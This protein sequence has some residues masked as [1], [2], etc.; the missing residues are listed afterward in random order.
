MAIN[1]RTEQ[2]AHEDIRKLIIRFSTPTIIGMLVMASYNIVDGIFVGRGVGSLA[3]S[4]IGVYFPLMRI[5]MAFGMLIGIGATSRVSLALGRKDHDEAEKILGNAITLSIVI[6]FILTTICY[7]FLE[8]IISAFGGTGVVYNYA[9]D[10]TK[11]SLIGAFFQTI[12][13]GLNSVIRG[14]GNPKTAMFTMII[15]SLINFALNP[16]FIFV[17][18]W[19]I[20]GSAWATVIAQI[21]AVIWIS[22]YYLGSQSVLK[23]HVKNLRPDYRIIKSIFSIGISPFA[24]QMVGSVVFIIFNKLLAIYGG[25]HAI[26][27]GRIGNNITMVILMPIFGLNQG[28]Q[29]IIGY[30]YGAKNYARVK[31]TLKQALIAA[32]TICIGGF[33]LVEIFSENIISLFV[34]D[35]PLVMSFA[36]RA[37]R[38]L[39]LML[40]LL[41]FQIISANY[42]QAIG[43][44]SRSLI[45]TLSRQAIFLIPLLLILPHYYGMDGIWLSEP[46]SDASSSILAAILIFSERTNL[47]IMTK[48]HLESAA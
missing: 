3:L 48:E 33:L 23:L 28:C 2:L 43:K 19:G 22:K 13:F 7:L 29:P 24:M 46:I 18:H 9:V 31:E 32:T 5:Y 1:Q 14:E 15:S 16:I 4:A 12:T 38:I 37:L 34:K 36:P 47:N 41:G 8:S 10:Y 42:F 40:P 45:L 20:R 39:L 11:V 35:D 27:A 30:N 44:A 26:G 6:S 21:I 17:L 25:Q